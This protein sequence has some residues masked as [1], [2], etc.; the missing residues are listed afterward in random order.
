MTSLTDQPSRRPTSK[1]VAGTSAGG[2]ALVITSAARLIGVELE[3]EVAG[4]L[5]LAAAAVVAYL[6]RERRPLGSTP[7][8]DG[9]PQHA[10]AGR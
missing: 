10:A 5:V 7:G 8:T 4:G 9:I 6:K 3:P 1:V 2:A